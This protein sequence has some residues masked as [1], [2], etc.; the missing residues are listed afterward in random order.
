MPTVPRRRAWRF[1][2]ADP[3]IEN[4]RTGGTDRLPLLN[5][6]VSD[7]RRACT[8]MSCLVR[9]TGYYM[10]C[11][12]GIE[13]SL[14]AEVV[15][16]RKALRRY[17]GSP[18]R[19]VRSYEVSSDPTDPVVRALRLLRAFVH[20][21]TQAGRGVKPVQTPVEQLYIECRTSTP[22]RVHGG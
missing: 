8:S 22:L 6:V 9:L 11:S 5:M 12:T 2:E 1:G 4:V 17:S 13:E 3:Q 10:L 20:G 18:G 19:V 16:P 21:S 7:V 14:Q 15:G